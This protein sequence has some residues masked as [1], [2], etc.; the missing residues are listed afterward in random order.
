MGK[1]FMKNVYL[2]AKYL[3]SRSSPL[4]EVRWA[5]YSFR[6]RLQ[7]NGY[8]ITLAAVV[9]PDMG[10]YVVQASACSPED[11]HKFDRSDAANRA[12]GRARQLAFKLEVG[13]LEETRQT[14]AGTEEECVFKFGTEE[15]FDMNSLLKSIDPL[16]EKVAKNAEYTALQDALK[17]LQKKHPNFKVL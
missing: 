9:L 5:E 3:A 4:L 16:Y 10:G 8:W 2:P 11:A 6:S 15:G 13:V 17:K 12:L 1:L 14:L 7:P